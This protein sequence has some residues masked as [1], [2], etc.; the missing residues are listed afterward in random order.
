MTPN[1]RLSRRVE[2]GQRAL[3]GCVAHIKCGSG[4]LELRNWQTDWTQL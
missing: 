4:G 3:S 2:E 1:P